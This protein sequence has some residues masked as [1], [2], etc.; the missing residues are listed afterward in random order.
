M[1]TSI[2][3]NKIEFILLDSRGIPVLLHEEVTTKDDE[4]YHV[5]GGSA[6][7]KPSSTG[8]VWVGDIRQDEE[9]NVKGTNFHREFYPTVLEMSWQNKAEHDQYWAEVAQAEQ[10]H[11]EAGV[12]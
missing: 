12:L 2:G 10:R 7:H 9:G 1:I 8:K 5:L 11:V 6:P 4:T 3:Y